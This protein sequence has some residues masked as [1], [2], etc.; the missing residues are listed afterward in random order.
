[1]AFYAVI[2]LGDSG[3]F[4]QR[5]TEFSMTNQSGEDCCIIASVNGQEEPAIRA[6][7]FEGRLELHPGLK[8]TLVPFSCFQKHF[9][10]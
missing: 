5:L 6:Q 7:L 9:L 2:F 10:G 4:L 8:L 1:M 3:K